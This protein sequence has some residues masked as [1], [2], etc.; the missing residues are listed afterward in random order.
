MDHVM[1]MMESYASTLEEQVEE[2]TKQLYHEQ[3]KSD[4][5]LYRMMPRC[6]LILY[7]A[8]FSAISPS[9]YRAFN[10]T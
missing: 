1:N 5:L 2:R 7:F 8:I 4:M 3:K 10:D 9:V 6:V